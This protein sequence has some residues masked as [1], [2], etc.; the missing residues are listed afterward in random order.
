[1]REAVRVLRPGGRLR[2]V[3]DGADQ[4]AAV[5]RR[6]GDRSSA[7]PLARRLWPGP[8]SF[9]VIFADPVGPAE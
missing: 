5:M 9:L 1:V 8:W 3:D 4:Y 7:Y 2:I 6:E